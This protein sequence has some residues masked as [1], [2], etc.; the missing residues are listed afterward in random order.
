MTRSKWYRTNICTCN[1]GLFTM[2][3][4][5]TITR[6]A[7]ELIRIKSPYVFTM[8][9]NRTFDRS[10]EMCNWCLER[11]FLCNFR[12]YRL[13]S[14]LFL[15]QHSTWYKFSAN[16]VLVV[17]QKHRYSGKQVPVNLF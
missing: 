9:G 15:S 14:K 11:D 7:L 4:R 2:W 8:I 12:S 16:G 1:F 3:I 10:I 13:I 5:S 17:F 6:T